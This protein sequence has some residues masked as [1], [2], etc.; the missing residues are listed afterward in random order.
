M[1]VTEIKEEIE[2]IKEEIKTVAHNAAHPEHETERQAVRR[3][4]WMPIIGA[5]V[6]AVILLGLYFLIMA[7]Q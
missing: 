5:T 2:E 3:Q 1:S 7:I 4:P 6:G